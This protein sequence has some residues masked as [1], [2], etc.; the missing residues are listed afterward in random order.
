MKDVLAG[1]HAK[2]GEHL[3]PFVDKTV[4]DALGTDLDA[5]LRKGVAAVVSELSHDFV[6]APRRE[7]MAVIHECQSNPGAAEATANRVILLQL[8]LDKARLR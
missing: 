2:L 8:A 3:A 1:A 6:I 7:L 5:V 4:L